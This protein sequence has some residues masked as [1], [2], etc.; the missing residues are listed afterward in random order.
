MRNESAAY[1]AERVVLSRRLLIQ[2]LGRFHPLGAILFPAA[3]V[4]CQTGCEG[5]EEP[6][7]KEVLELSLEEVEA[8]TISSSLALVQGV[9]GPS[10]EALVWENSRL[11]GLER[12]SLVELCP[13]KFQR[14]LSVSF[15][16]SGRAEIVGGGAQT[17]LVRL[18]GHECEDVPL[19]SGLSHVVGGALVAGRWRL[20]SIGPLGV[21]LWEGTPN[22]WTS[23][24]LDAPEVLV[25]M[26]LLAQSDT[27]P[28]WVAASE[29]GFLVNVRSNPF[30]WAQ[31]TAG[32]R[33][34][35]KANPL[36]LAPQ[37]AIGHNWVSTGVVDLSQGFLQVIADLSSDRRLLLLFSSEQEPI[38]SR[39]IRLP[40]GLLAARPADSTILAL[41]RTD[42]LELVRYRYSWN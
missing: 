32:V 35:L 10:G 29:E 31:I 27:L 36:I 42:R 7:S 28:V 12:D 19:P 38:R 30:T 26:L 25:D 6:A 20:L 37:S 14:I 22:A 4:V 17:H 1:L 21:A 8:I 18:A 41:R 23:S 34:Q 16:D 40:F 5:A 9:L 24:S 15:L 3:L 39:E 2:L 33:T 11:W 13:N